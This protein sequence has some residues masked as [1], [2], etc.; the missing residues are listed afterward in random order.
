MRIDVTHDVMFEHDLHFVLLDVPVCDRG[1][2]TRDPSPP[3]HDAFTT[4]DERA[5]VGRIEALPFLHRAADQVEHLLVR[6][7][8]GGDPR[9]SVAIQYDARLSRGLPTARG[10]KPDAPGPA[11]AEPLRDRPEQH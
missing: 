5:S 4:I 10:P 11:L 1:Q 9:Q 3:R 8:P 7:R 6:G 2:E